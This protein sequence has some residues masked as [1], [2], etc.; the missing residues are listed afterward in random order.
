MNSGF[1]GGRSRGVLK[2][3]TRDGKY[4]VLGIRGSFR[5]TAAGLE[6]IKPRSV[7]NQ[8]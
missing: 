5:A 3:M 6:K 7:R 4:Q 1:V 8:G 2:I